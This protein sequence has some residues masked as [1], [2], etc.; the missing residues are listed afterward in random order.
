MTT[1]I[2]QIAASPRRPLPALSLPLLG[3][4]TGIGGG[5]QN[6]IREAVVKG[7]QAW[8]IFSRNPR[9]W[10]A[11]PLGDEAINLFR[12]TRAESGLNPCIIHS[13]YLINLATSV[14]DVRIKS[15]TAFRDEI[16]RGL[17]LGADYLVVHPGSARGAP[18]EQAI[19]VARRH[20]A[21]Q[22]AA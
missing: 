3:V 21:R 17:S 8:Q 10:T 22:R 7:C 13:C 18:I 12:R 5:I 9:G 6:S 1:T 16:V 19:K 4:H 11:R 2:D 15:I 20:C 14:P